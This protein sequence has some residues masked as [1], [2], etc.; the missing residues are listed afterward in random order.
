[1]SV[2]VLLDLSDFQKKFFY[3]SKMNMIKVTFDKV[4]CKTG[5]KNVSCYDVTGKIL[6]E[7]NQQADDSKIGYE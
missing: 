2:K 3:R 1:M 7:T 6:P 5:S 4:P